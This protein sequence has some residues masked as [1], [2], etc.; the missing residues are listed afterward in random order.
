MKCCSC[1]K[2]S[3]DE[4]V[5]YEHGTYT[6]CKDC[7]N[8]DVEFINGRPHLPIVRYQSKNILINVTYKK[9]DYDK[10]IGNT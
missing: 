1:N 10:L 6:L 2:K 3:S 5:K 7:F 4:T 8:R 9:Y